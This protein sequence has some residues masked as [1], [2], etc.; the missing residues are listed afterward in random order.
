MDS[1]DN[2]TERRAKIMDPTE[3]FIEGMKGRTIED[4]V[5]D[6]VPEHL[7]KDGAY[8][9]IQ[10][11]IIFVK[12][13]RL[14]WDCLEDMADKE[15]LPLEEIVSMGLIGNEFLCKLIIL[16]MLRKRAGGS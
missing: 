9:E 13:P 4:V 11:K 16:K 1:G 15:E 14:M 10:G 2:R 12:L 7:R 5:E 8:M 3:G 6:I